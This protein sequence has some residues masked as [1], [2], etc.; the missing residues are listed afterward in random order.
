VPQRR[1]TALSAL[2]LLLC[3]T[4]VALWAT[5]G[6]VVL[7]R[8][9]ASFVTAGWERGLLIFESFHFPQP[10]ADVSTVYRF[11]GRPRSGRPIR[12]EPSPRSGSWGGQR[13]A[14]TVDSEADYA[15][16]LGTADSLW[17]PLWPVVLAAAVL[18]VMQVRR[19]ARA[20]RASR[21]GL[22]R[23]CGYD[24]RATPERCPECGRAAGDGV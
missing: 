4:A 8:T 6:T 21:S 11:S 16:P 7:R 23:A 12:S 14:W 18:P 17:F 13:G 20:R 22:C 24:L 15:E 10:R 9:P 3:L 1:F 2:S 19:I 5:E